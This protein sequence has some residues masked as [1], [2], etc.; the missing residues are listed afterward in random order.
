[1]ISVCIATY[2]GE[3]FILA[4]IESILKQLAA[5]DEIIISDDGSIDKTIEYIKSFED[6]RIKI[7]L[8]DN[9]RGFTSN[10]QNALSKAE[11]DFIFLA[12]QDDIWL[13]NKVKITLDALQYSD[14]VISDCL[15]VDENLNI[16]NNSRFHEFN[17]KGT[18]LEHFL[19]SRYIGCCMAFN[20]K[21]LDTVLPFPL[22]YKVL[23]HDIWIAAVGLTYFKTTL[24]RE[25]LI[26]YRRHSNNVSSGGFNNGYPLLV[27]LYKR[28]YRLYAL[29]RIN[30][31][32]SQIKR[33]IT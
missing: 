20:K 33:S 6:S 3:E 11:G 5:N 23:E 15:T 28:L 21:I 22:K 31:K 13:D 4:Q 8:N 30:S 26:M 2:N 1:M 16:L 29:V 10:F 27:K 18:K 12:D 9:E 24:I 19:K 14:L 25:P 32:V 7:Y 17:I